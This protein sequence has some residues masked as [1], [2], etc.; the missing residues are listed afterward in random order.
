MFGKM[1]V[2]DIVKWHGCFGCNAA[3]E[4]KVECIEVV[5]AY[6]KEG[7]VEVDEC[8]WPLPANRIV[9]SLDNGHWAYGSQIESIVKRPNSDLE[10]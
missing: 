3:Q 5:D 4:A 8:D 2:G 9:V 1:K 10:A 6:E 7:G